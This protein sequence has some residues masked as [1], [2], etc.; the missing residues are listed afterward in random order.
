[1]YNDK[2]LRNVIK[3][4][5]SLFSL[6]V[7]MLDCFY[8]TF[9][10]FISRCHLTIYVIQNFM[11]GSIYFLSTILESFCHSIGHQWSPG[12]PLK[13]QVLVTIHKVNKRYS[14]VSWHAATWK[15]NVKYL[16][17]RKSKN[18]FWDSYA[19]KHFTIR[20]TM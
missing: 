6:I 5:Y 3:Q 14:A 10:I 13:S 20:H 11:L 15:R 7:N 19:Q 4:K 18:V 17:A 2:I 8:F 1:M 12:F 16:I 9:Y